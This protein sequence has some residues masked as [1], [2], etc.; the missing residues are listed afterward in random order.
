MTQPTVTVEDAYGRPGRAVRWHHPAAAPTPDGP[1]VLTATPRGVYVT[2]N[3]AHI[4]DGWV[5][6]ARRAHNLLAADP[7]ADLRWI[8]TQDTP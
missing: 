8:A 3:L 4:P 6:A 5:Q 7:A 2:G 1:P